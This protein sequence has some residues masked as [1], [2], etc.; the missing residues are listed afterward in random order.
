MRIR[1][2][3]PMRWILVAISLDTVVS[4]AVKL[5]VPGY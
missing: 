1:G 4:G 5:L 2:E 3:R